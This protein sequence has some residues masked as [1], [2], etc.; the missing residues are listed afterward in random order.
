[1]PIEPAMVEV[2]GP[3]EAVVP[4]LHLTVASSAARIGHQ[5]LNRQASAADEWDRRP[6]APLSSIGPETLAAH[7]GGMRRAH[8][9]PAAIRFN[10]GAAAA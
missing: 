7:G 10:Y 9:S 4:P 5:C 8:L 2:L 6:P 1:M 3:Q